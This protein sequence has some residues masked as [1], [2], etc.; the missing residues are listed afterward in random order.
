MA[1]GPESPKLDNR[2]IE[3][4]RA[5]RPRKLGSQRRLR[6]GAGTSYR[7]RRPGY[8]QRWGPHQA[9]RSAWLQRSL[10]KVS[11]GLAD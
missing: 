4:D 11:T 10:D 2:V 7:Y 1:D 8:H 5:E 6:A 9:G 3:S